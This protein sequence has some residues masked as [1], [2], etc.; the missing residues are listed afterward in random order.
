MIIPAIFQQQQPLAMIQYDNDAEP[1]NVYKNMRV[2]ITQNRD[3]DSGVV[4]GQEAVVHLK[5]NASIL[6]RL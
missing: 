2:I 3:K 1:G 5:E 6:L 4:N